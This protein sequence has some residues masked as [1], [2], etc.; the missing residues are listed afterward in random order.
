MIANCLKCGGDG[1][2]HAGQ[3][4]SRIMD[5]YPCPTCNP[6]PKHY[7]P[8][9]VALVKAAREV[10]ASSTDCSTGGELRISVPSEHM[11]TLLLSLKPFADLK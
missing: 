1:V 2:I 10:F 8:E 11:M 4:N 5:V 7:P 9:V 3:Q 6:Q